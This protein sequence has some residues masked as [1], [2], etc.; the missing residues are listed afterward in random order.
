MIRILHEV[1]HPA[2]YYKV[3]SSTATNHFGKPDSVGLRMRTCHHLSGIRFSSDRERAIL[4][5][6]GIGFATDRIATTSRELL[7]HGFALTGPSR[8]HRDGNIDISKFRNVDKPAVYF[9]LLLLPPLPVVIE[10]PIESEHCSRQTRN[11]DFGVAVS[12]YP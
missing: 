6:H 8:F 7:P 2:F 5:L 4:L 9:L 10:T 11:I 1:S 3:A 12:D